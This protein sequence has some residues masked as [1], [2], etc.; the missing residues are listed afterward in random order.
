MAYEITGGGLTDAVIA[1]ATPTYFGWLA[2]WNTTTVANGTYSLQSVAT[3]T[4][5]VNVTGPTIAITVNNSPPSTVILI[6]ANGS[7]MDSVNS[8]V[9]DAVASP[10]VTTVTFVTTPTSPGFVPESFPAIPTIYGWI[11]TISTGGPACGT[12][13]AVRV[14]LSVQTVAS[15]SGGVSGSSP[16]VTTTLIIHVPITGL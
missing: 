5:G 6:P 2:L 15:Y 1:T 14:P 7:T 12:C 16:P 13:S 8:V 11:A 10:G 4:G 9:W 3:Y